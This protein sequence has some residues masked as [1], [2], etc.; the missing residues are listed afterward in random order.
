MNNNF[1]IIFVSFFKELNLYNSLIL[2]SNYL[3]VP[4]FYI[5]TEVLIQVYKLSLSCETLKLQSFKIRHLLYN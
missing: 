2:C 1:S 4:N 3:K 5:E